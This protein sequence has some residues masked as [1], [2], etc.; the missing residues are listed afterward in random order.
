MSDYKSPGDMTNADW[1][2]QNLTIR[3]FK[4][5]A[6]HVISSALPGSYTLAGEFPSVLVSK[7]TSPLVTGFVAEGSQGSYQVLIRNLADIP[8]GELKAEDSA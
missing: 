2:Q 8:P 1:E 4:W 5:A 7:A 6:E 3:L